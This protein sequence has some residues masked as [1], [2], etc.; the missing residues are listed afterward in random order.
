[1]QDRDP[2]TQNWS[3]NLELK[4]IILVGQPS[5]EKIDNSSVKKT[6]LSYKE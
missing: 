2:Q 5:T 1:M 6:D 3:I 4:L